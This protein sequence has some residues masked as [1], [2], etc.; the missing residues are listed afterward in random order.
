MVQA[1]YSQRPSCPAKAV[2]SGN[3]ITGSQ[4]IK[5]TL[6]LVRSSWTRGLFPA[7]G[8]TF[9]E[10]EVG[11]GAAAA[12]HHCHCSRP[13]ATS[14]APPHQQSRHTCSG[15]GSRRSPE[16]CSC[17]SDPWPYIRAWLAPAPRS[18]LSQRT[19]RTWRSARC[20]FAH[21]AIHRQT[22]IFTEVPNAC[23]LWP[24]KQVMRSIN[25]K[26]HVNFQ[27][28]PHPLKEVPYFVHRRIDTREIAICKIDTSF[29]LHQLQLL[30][31]HR[32]ALCLLEAH[33]IPQCAAA[34]AR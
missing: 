16:P 23:V 19:Q 9:C 25:K 28:G 4:V 32:L 12:Q 17:R 1:C 31:A 2:Q 15:Y 3:E 34:P 13:H 24:T 33:T 30:Q 26:V 21:D 11:A 14:T 27:V 5:L 7:P 6:V 18:V 10:E 29:R 20:S 22:Q 8:H